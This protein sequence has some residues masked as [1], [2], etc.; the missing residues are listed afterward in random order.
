VLID[1]ASAHHQ[2]TPEEAEEYARA[3][4]EDIVRQHEESIRREAEKNAKMNRGGTDEATRLREERLARRKEKASAIGTDDSVLQTEDV[5]PPQTTTTTTIP[6]P[7][8]PHLVRIAGSS[9]DLSN[10]RPSPENTYTSL[11]SAR[12]AGV[13]SYPSTLHERA[14]CGVFRALWETGHFMGSGLKFGGDFLVYLGSFTW[15]PLWGKSCHN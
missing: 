11:E 10:Y 6:S 7:S 3:H 9:S 1:D 12:E 8:I 15:S 4:E 5:P 14:K 13:W 2:A